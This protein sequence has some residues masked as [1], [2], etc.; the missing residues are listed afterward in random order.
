MAQ[1]GSQETVQ[2]VH[3]SVERV[4]LALVQARRTLQLYPR[5]NPL[6]REA[7]ERLGLAIRDSAAHVPDAEELTCEIRADG[8]YLDNARLG[9]TRGDVS[10]FALILYRDGAKLF[11]F[12]TDVSVQDAVEFIE[13]VSAVEEGKTGAEHRPQLTRS[14]MGVEYFEEAVIAH[15]E[16]L[17]EKVAE[18]DALAY[19]RAQRSLRSK[20]GKSGAHLGEVLNFLIAAENGSEKE[21][22]LLLNTLSDPAKLA[23]MLS[24]VCHGDEEAN[25]ASGP[26][27]AHAL[28]QTLSHIEICV[29]EFPKEMRDEL[30]RNLSEAIL[31]T[32][33]HTREHVLNSVLA[34]KVD[35][36]GLERDIAASLPPRA[37]AD[38]LL[39][40][41]QIHDG[42][43]STIQGFLASFS[44]DKRG[45]VIRSFSQELDTQP[46]RPGDIPEQET[47][48]TL[49]AQSK[50]APKGPTP[51]PDEIEKR[52]DMLRTLSQ[53]ALSVTAEESQEVRRR[54]AA[55]N[56][57]HDQQQDTLTYFHLYALGALG[58][59][60]RLFDLLQKTIQQAALTRDFAFVDHVLQLA[61]GTLRTDVR[62]DA[63]ATLQPYLQSL[64][65]EEGMISF[66]D[67]L[68]K[69]ANSDPESDAIHRALE[70][71]AGDATPALFQRLEQEV[72]KQQRFNL[73]SVLME[74]GAPALQFLHGQLRH[75]QWYVVRN[76]VYLMGRL[77][78]EANFP[79]LAQAMKHPDARVRQE[80]VKAIA[81]T[82]GPG[83]TELL[84]EALKDPEFTL[85]GIA[86]ELL[87]R[88]GSRDAGPVL[89]GQLQANA[90]RLRREPEGALGLLRALSQLGGPEAL[91]PIRRF[92]FFTLL[93]GARR[94][95]QLRAMARFARTQIL[96]R[97]QTAEQ[98]DAGS[99]EP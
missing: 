82:P 71:I 44:Q 11:R 38:V 32:D 54:T 24:F 22:T 52:L 75:P 49:I 69:L 60:P 46:P 89:S 72:E 85:R 45:A 16:A 21:Q 90:W 57:T 14:R 96:Q 76:A 50:P 30:I 77:P 4:L 79:H 39:R 47:L 48:R 51:R 83:A 74:L 5:A 86:A 7:L 2:Q 68:T 67:H 9:A 3:R 15:G 56:D 12:R 62:D 94:R 42:T 31:T 20:D 33:V 61:V 63:Y 95:P 66:L 91:P 35:A 26:R 55:A 29:K 98:H 65:S 6:V 43:A 87:A 13:A 19:F 59:E 40:H 92:L 84:I 78:S 80:A 97:L 28:Q 25:Q 18:L 41:L 1:A 58:Q 81:A 88:S 27:A 8:F 36:Q 34:A 53:E 23:E 93:P 37:S 10:K 64:Y 73:L 17:P 70:A 99:E